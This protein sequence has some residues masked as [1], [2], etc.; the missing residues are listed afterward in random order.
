MTDDKVLISR[1]LL[2]DFMAHCAPNER[3]SLEHNNRYYA[4][5]CELIKSIDAKP[6]DGALTNEPI[7]YR[8]RFHKEPDNWMACWKPLPVERNPHCE[9]QAL[10]LGTEVA[11]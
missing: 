10:H 9:Y 2:K 6:S 4:L 8:V 3:A 1:N 11:S 5:A 7:G